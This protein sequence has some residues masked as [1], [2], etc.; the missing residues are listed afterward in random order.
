MSV[1]DCAR[2]FCPYLQRDVLSNVSAVQGDLLATLLQF[3]RLL[4]AKYLHSSRE[5]EAK[6]LDLI[7]RHCDHLL[8]RSKELAIHRLQ[9]VDCDRRA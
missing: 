7:R 3:H 2:L 8:H 1:Q 6:H 4:L 5:V 9:I